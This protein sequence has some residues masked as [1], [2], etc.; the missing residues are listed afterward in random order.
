[1][2]PMR[3][4]KVGYFGEKLPRKLYSHTIQQWIIHAA[5]SACSSRASS[6]PSSR[7]SSA[8]SRTSSCTALSQY[9]QMQTA[10]DVSVSRRP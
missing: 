7:P 4:N 5:A 10:D 6:R 8:G 3:W 2:P 1:M 9:S